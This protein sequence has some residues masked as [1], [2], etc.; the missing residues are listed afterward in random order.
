[1]RFKTFAGVAAASGISIVGTGCGSQAPAGPTASAAAT[2]GGVF[3]IKLEAATHAG[4]P[5]CGAAI[6]DTVGYVVSP[7]SLWRCE[8]ANWTQITCTAALSGTLAY[9]AIGTSGTQTILVC[10]GEKW[11]QV[12]LPAGPQGPAGENGMNGLNG[13]NG[14]NGMNGANG[15]T[16]AAGAAGAT[17]ATGAP[18]AAGT[19]GATGATG[20]Q[21]AAGTTGAQGPA[22]ATG[23]T[24]PTG[25]TGPQ[26]SGGAGA[27]GATGPVG[28]TGPQGFAGAV[29]ATG[30][31][32]PQGV[33][34]AVGATGAQGAAS[35]VGFAVDSS[36]TLSSV[37]EST[38]G[39][40]V[41]DPA[42]ASFTANF[43]GNCV[44]S[45]EGVLTPDVGAQPGSGDY[46]FIVTGSTSGCSVAAA[47]I[48]SSPAA[49]S[50]T[51]VSGLQVTAGESVTLGCDVFYTQGWVPSALEC[52]VSWVCSPD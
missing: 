42:G 2:T 10:A 21:G 11:S 30:A 5:T 23:A 50:C 13:L 7:P 38:L 9:G 39:E 48:G 8:S 46:A 22:G 25:P 12:Q 36:V 33:A 16:G 20:A 37:G 41:D 32:G 31:T 1:M 43:T 29:G 40:T 45:V 34:G 49:A 6:N 3:A 19:A 27:T 24:G 26:G 28:P 17:G 14:Q 35:Q 52:S 47:A 4:L 51:A 15:A 44:I 18:G